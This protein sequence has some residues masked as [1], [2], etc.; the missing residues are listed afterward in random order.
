[1]KCIVVL[2]AAAGLAGAQIG[3]PLPGQSPYPGGYPYPGGNRIPG[4]GRLPPTGG[5]PSPGTSNP[6]QPLPSFRGTLKHLDAK[7]LTLELDDYRVLDFRITN[8]TKYFKDK[9]E[10]KSS[11][12]NAGDVVSVEGPYDAAG[13]LTALNVYWEKAAAAVAAS[14]NKDKENTKDEGTVDTWKDKPAERATES[15][16]PPASKD[17]EDPGPPTLKRGKP[18]QRASTPDPQPDTPAAPATPAKTA[19]ARTD[20]PKAEAPRQVAVNLPPNTVPLPPSTVTSPPPTQ[21][22]P[23]PG[24]SPSPNLVN[25]PPSTVSLPR[26]QPREDVVVNPP[27]DSEPALER[28]PLGVH[29]EDAL[30]RKAT[31]AA[32][33]FTETLPNYVCQEVVLRFESDAKPPSWHAI[34]IVSTDVVYENGKEDYRNIT[35]NGKPAAKNLEQTGAWST[36]EFGTLLI[37]LFSPATAAEFHPRGEARVA[38]ITAKLYSF[39][40]KRENSHWTLHFGSQTY[41][42]AYSG[43]TWIDPRTS[44]VLRI[45]MEARGLPV[46]FPTDHVE[47]A[48]DYQYI[49]LG[50][51]QEYLLPVHSEILSCQRGTSDC[52]KNSIDFRNYHKY[53]GESTIQFG[54]EAPQ[55][56]AAPGPP[57]S[58][59]RR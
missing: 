8:K 32:L 36:G 41:Q 57:Q 53:T 7:S 13:A 4:A 55:N 5:S 14:G 19:Q 42:P 54:N 43:S 3:F 34:D 22:A 1:M 25:L 30:I 39:D 45:E 20:Q 24:V 29:Q 47:S 52:S 31:E 58:Q 17:P 37:D 51:T 10:V 15:A 46:G 18:A 38:G 56:P 35:V 2:I 40:V 21:Q 33:E 27:D 26:P 48:T 28:L 11:Q 16:P 9:Q 23:S 50:G 12:F 44:R 59:P 49:R 6:N